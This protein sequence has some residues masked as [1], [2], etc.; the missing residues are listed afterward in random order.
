[1]ILLSGVFILI[2]FLLALADSHIEGA[3]EKFVYSNMDDLPYNRVGLLLG[4]S[5]STRRGATNWYFKNRITAAKALLNG[6]KVKY[7]I[8]S[9]DNSRRGYNEPQDMKDALIKEGIDSSRLYLDFAGLRTFD[10]VI[11]EKEVFGQ[12]KITIVSQLFHNE[13]ALY[14]AQRLG[15]EAIA[16]NANDVRSRGGLKT[17]IREKFARV[18]AIADFIF[19]TEAK[20]LGDFI[21]IGDKG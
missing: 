16:F 8:I 12:S 2:V 13:R 1:M 18:L 3:T 21:P 19:G 20:F 10:S 15:L 9:G 14:I 11:R 6:N 17:K 4:T 7:L 5:K